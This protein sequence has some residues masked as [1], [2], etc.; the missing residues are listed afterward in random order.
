M[1]EVFPTP[2]SPL[3]PILTLKEVFILSTSQM[4]VYDIEQSKAQSAR[5]C[6]VQKFD[7]RQPAGCGISRLYESKVLLA[8]P[9]MIAQAGSPF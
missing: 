4:A 2:L 8:F 7:A 5:G 6:R 1:S 9:G 3:T